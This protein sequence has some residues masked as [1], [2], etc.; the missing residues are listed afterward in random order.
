[1]ATDTDT[2]SD[3]DFKREAA[4]AGELMDGVREAIDASDEDPI[5]V[6]FDMWIEMTRHLAEGG[7]TAVELVAAVQWHVADQTS[8]GRA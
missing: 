6:M 4:L 2:T 8:D 5:G 1:M 3:A 7:W